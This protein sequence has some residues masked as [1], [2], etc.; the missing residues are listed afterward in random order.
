MKAS[1]HKQAAGRSDAAL[2]LDGH[3]RAAL[4]TLQSLGRMGVAVD[5]AAEKECLGWKSRYC[6]ARVAQPDSADTQ[7]FRS[8]LEAR[9]AAGDYRLIVPST[10]TS[11]RCLL[12]LPE[13]HP[14]RLAAVLPSNRALEIALSKQQTWDLARSLGVW[15]PGSRLISSRDEAGEP[16]CFPLVLKPA[17]SLV[18][19]GDQLIGV[20][21]KIVTTRE[22][23]SRALDRLLPLCPV[24]EQE[25]ISGRGV[26][27]ECLYRNG[28]CLWHFQ[29][30]RLHELPLTGGGSSYRRSVPVD[31]KLLAAAAR[32]LDSLEWHGVAMVEFRGSADHGYRLM[33]INPRL[34]G[35]LAL[36]IDAGVDF[37][38][39]LW[40][41][42]TD[43][44]PGPE[45][46]YKFP[47]YTR[48]LRMDFDW[49]KENLRADHENPLLLTSS[50]FRSLVEY[51]RPL[52]GRES[53]DH[54]DLKDWRIW[55][56]VLLEI[57][58]L[59]F[60]TVLSIMG[61]ALRFQV[62]LR[63]HRKILSRLVEVNRGRVRR[64]LFVCYGNICRSPL[65]E[66]YAKRLCPDLEVASA[67]FH[68]AVDRVAPEWY[69]SIVAELG[70]DLSSCRSK[71]IDAAQVEWAQLILLADF[72][73]LDRFEREFSKSM[74]KT[75]MLGFFL[76][77][78][79]AVIEDPYDLQP[80]DA[81]MAVQQ[82][83]AAV[84][85][86]VVW[87]RLPTNRCCGPFA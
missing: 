85:G 68:D 34:W 4:E 39:G 45:P 29:H 52:F 63:R 21:P 71:R 24:L 20:T 55:G 41:I 48:N 50:R 36:P 59:S 60:R 37:P 79:R 64:I 26:G 33:E 10:E 25:Y 14:I 17:A 38:K 75:T 65:A 46:K 77:A 54:F 28:A 78:P 5:L 84:N 27:I 86:L 56:S 9:Y 1:S 61:K 53:W 87:S 30:E 23:W 73:N 74:D 82:V 6:R 2:V 18:A 70:V 80:T 32:L 51:G 62:A 69:Q 83:L 11:L 47:Y 40:C 35:S 42:A 22:E 58:N 76:P 43:Q 7:V 49:L 16:G 13:A 67:G 44:D 12:L 66:L 57:L 19:V 72:D 8:W 81:R 31:E 15:V 3:S